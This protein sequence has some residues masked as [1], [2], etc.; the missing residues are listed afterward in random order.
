[1]ENTNEIKL[2]NLIKRADEGDEDAIYYYIQYYLMD[3]SASK[4]EGLKGK[5]DDYVKK[6]ASSGKPSALI[7]LGQ[8]SNDPDVTEKYYM[9]AGEAG[10]TAGYEFLAENYMKGVNGKTDYK[11]AYE[12]LKRS[13]DESKKLR[14]DSG[15]YYMGELYYF[16]LFVD[17]DWDIAKKYYRRV[18]KKYNGSDYYWRACAR[19]STIYETI[20][21]PDYIKSVEQMKRVV[22]KHTE[23]MTEEEIAKLLGVYKK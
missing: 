19:L 18:I 22:A 6:L 21:K 1:M 15:L 10:E 9:E 11:K 13:E 5:Y 23:G 17:K 2:L 3:E 12:L 4:N 14:S 7:Y 20:D 16:G 8:M